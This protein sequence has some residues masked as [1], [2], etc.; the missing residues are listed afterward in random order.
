MERSG[1]FDITVKEYDGPQ[2]QIDVRYCTSHQKKDP[3]TC[4]HLDEAVFIQG[5]SGVEEP[6]RRAAVGA[7]DG[8]RKRNL[9]TRAKMEDIRGNREERGEKDVV[10]MYGCVSM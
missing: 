10:D 7:P 6:L 3:H 8:F 2:K 1:T 4:M 9:C 5:Q